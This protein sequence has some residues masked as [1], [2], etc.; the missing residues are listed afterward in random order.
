MQ[1]GP[2]LR[3][4]AHR[5]Q[6]SATAWAR[7]E[8]RP[9]GGL[10]EQTRLAA[11]EE[12]AAIDE[13]VHD[14]ATLRLVPRSHADRL[15]ALAAALVDE[16]LERAGLTREIFAAFEAGIPRNV[17]EAIEDVTRG[18]VPVSDW[19]NVLHDSTVLT[20]VH[21][22][23]RV[24]VNDMN[25]AHKLAISEGSTVNRDAEFRRTIRKAKPKGY[26]QNGFAGAL[27]ISP[28]LLSMYRNG[29]RPAPRGIRE[30]A[31][32]LTGWSKSRWPKIAEED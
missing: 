1:R 22:K 30:K 2:R 11:Q 6:S 32:R 24:N 5:R 12:V 3:T 13:P 26:T 10:L 17:A 14:R 19:P 25:A 27:G 7:D 16:W 20:T 23:S 4:L 18:A 9:D 8:T 31:E 29:R 28:A 21:R 15:A